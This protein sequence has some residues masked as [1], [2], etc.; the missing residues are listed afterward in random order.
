M[1]S[2]APDFQRFLATW[3]LGKFTST[4]Q[5]WCATADCVVGLARAAP[6]LL[7]VQ[8]LLETDRCPVFCE[9]AIDYLPRSY[10][11]GKVVVLFDDTIN[12]GS[13]MALARRRLEALGATVRC[14]ATAVDSE[15]F[16]GRTLG[17]NK[18]SRF[19]RPLCA[20]WLSEFSHHQIGA[21]HN[22][23]VSQFRR[24]GKPYT[25]DYPVFSVP[26]D[27][28]ASRYSPGR[29]AE[30]I[31]ETADRPFLWPSSTRQIGRTLHSIS[32]P[33]PLSVLDHLVP[34]AKDLVTWR[35][36]S[37][38]RLYVDLDKQVLRVASMAQFDTHQDIVALAVADP[39]AEAVWC[40]LKEAVAED[41]SRQEKQRLLAYHRALVF[42]VSLG[43]ARSAWH[44]ILRPAL[45]SLLK[46]VVPTL[47]HVE[48]TLVF[49]DSLTAKICG[50]F[51][52]YISVPPNDFLAV[53]ESWQGTDDQE[54][55]PQKPSDMV[56]WERITRELDSPSTSEECR[57]RSD[58]DALENVGALLPVL[59]KTLD[60]DQRGTSGEMSRLETG[61]TFGDLLLLM[62]R[63]DCECSV[64]DLS[65]AIDVLV[66][67]GM[68]V[69]Q[70]LFQSEAKSIVRTYRSGEN[71]RAERTRQLR[72]VV[73][74]L[75]TPWSESGRHPL[76]EKGFSKVFV[77]L[78][79]LFPDL[80][81]L[82]SLRT[83][84]LESFVDET[85][86]RL[87]CEQHGVIDLVSLDKT[88]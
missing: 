20:E 30:L 21:F 28:C 40:L 75:L 18:P 62:Q 36:Y 86:L 45:T 44:S 54:G 26:L 64:L 58:R 29:I 38:L 61:L 32:I 50:A 11:D 15:V 85:E 68:L 83:Y 6:R 23:E 5:S 8:G 88:E 79:R 24:L 73:L 78:L 12:Y 9:R 47:S 19:M 43:M 1:I 63:A 37:K 59:R 51:S 84:G 10:F 33:V 71:D 81:Y 56:L 17:G 7:E 52:E 82:A 2:Q 70:L 80:P 13:T 65:F 14:F 66:D 27:G 39:C 53:S 69:P 72:A 57:P 16:L 87:W 25:V 77:I 41:P 35:P 67:E 34:N 31:G 55:A 22:A 74:R 42:S 4:F 46:P 3:G 76:S 60:N 48:P 49:G